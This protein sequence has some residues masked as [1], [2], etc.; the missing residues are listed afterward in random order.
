MT[1]HTQTAD[2]ALT[3]E[4]REREMLIW[5]GYRR[6]DVVGHN[7]LLSERYRA[8]HPDGS[9]HGKPT[10]QQIASEPMSAYQFSQFVAE[11]LGNDFALVSYIA[12]VEGPGPGGKQLH[13]RFVVGE[14]WAREGG[15]WKVRTY[16][17]TVVAPRET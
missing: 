12:D 3:R 9:I 13:A 2:E 5:E 7:A 17:P 4:I 6:G 10:A 15:Q 16:Q 1:P 14:V 8:V 11:P